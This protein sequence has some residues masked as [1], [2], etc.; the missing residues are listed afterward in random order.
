MNLSRRD[1]AGTGVLVLGAAALAGPGLANT[2]D[3]GAVK[4]AVEELKVAWLKQ[5]KATLEAMTLPQ[6]SYS[7]SDAR[8]EDKA[9]FIEGGHGAKGDRQVARVSR[10]D[11]TGGRQHRNR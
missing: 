3:E 5:D 10:N 7:H 11:G 4:K 1:L 6:L 9:K 2:E 8:L